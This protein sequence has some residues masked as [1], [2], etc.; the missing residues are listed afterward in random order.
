MVD[1][2][3]ARPL[4][5]YYHPATH[6][7]FYTLD[8]AGEYAPARGYR[9]QGIAGFI[10]DQ[11]QGRLTKPL[12]RWTKPSP[13]MHFYTTDPNGE[14]AAAAGYRPDGSRGHVVADEHNE[15]LPTT[16]LWRWYAH[17]PH[18][19]HF[20]STDPDGEGLPQ[21]GYRLEDLDMG[22]VFA[23][24]RHGWMRHLDGGR[25]ISAFTLP[26]TH[27]SA[28]YLYADYGFTKCQT[29]SIRAQ[30]D[31]GVRFLDIRC[32][33]N[34][35][36][37]HDDLWLFHGLSF[38]HHSFQTVY[39][40]CRDFLIAHPSECI[41]LSLKNEAKTFHRH[42]Q[43]L[44]R[45]RQYVAADPDRFHLGTALPTLDEVRGKMVLLRRF[46][47]DGL[48]I[49]LDSR[50][51]DNATERWINTGSV[52]CDVQDRFN[53]YLVGGKSK[54][55]ERVRDFFEHTP[56]H[57][58][59]D[60]LYLNFTSGTGGVWPRTLATGIDSGDSFPGTNAKVRDYLTGKPPG[61]YGIVPMD[62]PEYPDDSAL[63]ARLVGLNV[64]RPVTG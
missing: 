64:L 59:L 60:T 54:K 8:A 32:K 31:A 56:A 42:D 5:R 52:T 15:R 37:G 34:G 9:L 30:L 29:L 4:Y 57:T 28:T 21:H 35:D 11:P 16:K 58:D 46:K 38:L 49:D 22:E 27:D 3:R 36:G 40:Q 53:N 14:L 55:F 62:F 33:Y 51:P 25:R 1:M 7:F 13:L 2:D 18:G 20:Y 39:E 45:F 24:D 50:W 63:I 17:L 12:F 6:D 61:R 19:S 48:G 10:F 44:T 43:F 41:V 26:G 23:F 47:A